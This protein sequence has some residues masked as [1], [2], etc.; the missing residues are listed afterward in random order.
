MKIT[1]ARTGY[2]G[3]LLV[4]LLSERHEVIALDIIEDKQINILK[5]IL[6][7]KI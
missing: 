6:K 3:L 1:V 5:N 2:V 7:I 4:T